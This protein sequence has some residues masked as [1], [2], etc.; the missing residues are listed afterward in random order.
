M[1]DQAEDPITVFWDI[2]TARLDCS[3][4][5]SLSTYDVVDNIRAA[6]SRHGVIKTLR[7][8]WDT[9]TTSLISAS[10][11]RSEL[12]SSGVSLIDCP[13]EGRKGASTKRLLVDLICYAWDSR[14]SSTICVITE[15]RDLAYAIATLRMRKYRL[16]LMAPASAHQ[17]LM[18]QASVQMDWSRS[19]LGNSGTGPNDRDDRDEEPPPSSRPR[20]SFV[21][22]M[23]SHIPPPTAP[24]NARFKTFGPVHGGSAPSVEV[25]DM[26]PR[27]RRNSVFPK[28]YASDYNGPGSFWDGSMSPPPRNIPSFGLGDG[29]LF[30]RPHSRFRLKPSRSD[31]APPN[32]SHS[33][34]PATPPPTTPRPHFADAVLEPSVPAATATSKGK[35]RAFP[36][37]DTDDVAPLVT[38]SP[39]PDTSAFQPFEDNQTSTTRTV[40]PEWK[41][42]RAQAASVRTVSSSSRGDSVSSVIEQPDAS[43]AP[44]AAEHPDEDC[45]EK[46]QLAA[47]TMPLHISKT[48]ATPAPSASQPSPSSRRKEDS[49]TTGSVAATIASA[50]VKT[51]PQEVPKPMPLLQPAVASTST[52][53]STKTLPLHN[54]A[55]AAS[56]P[57]LSAKPPVIWVPLVN[58]LRSA[59]GNASGSSL[60]GLL[61]KDDPKTYQKAGTSKLKAYLEAAVAAGIVRT[62]G[63]RLTSVHVHLA[64][65]YK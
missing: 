17:D 23:A 56:S 31:S 20:G 59:G 9:A 6:I 49:C 30:P 14:P 21:E 61:L 33:S 64:N 41:G 18:S 27:C 37:Q 13:G 51:T 7:A 50:T 1:C 29:P 52:N 10:R 32:I 42:V 39:T 12:A 34:L 47:Q 62:T 24:L 26:A 2:E 65:P 46:Q 38:S 35:E 40:T 54:T 11:I 22:Q 15:D 45:N 48:P 28:V 4:A 36:I 3:A 60:G 25:H 53:A 55:V 57:A 43:S 44:T 19:S 16:L 63:S 8:Y 58:T 5:R